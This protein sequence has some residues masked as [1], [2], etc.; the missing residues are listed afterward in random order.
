[1]DER[2]ENILDSVREKAHCAAACTVGS[3]KGLGKIVIKKDSHIKTSVENTD[4]GKIFWEN[5]RDKSSG[6]SVL[7]LLITFLA[8]VVSLAA[9]ISV[10]R[11][12]IRDRKNC[13]TKTKELKKAKKLIEKY[14]RD[15]GNAEAK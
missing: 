3:V 14:E 7:R 6:C 15:L 12:G 2:F 10:I 5:E 13:R 1:M 11:T 9:V 8:V 4:S